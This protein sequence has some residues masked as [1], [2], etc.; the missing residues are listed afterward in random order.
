LAI[1]VF[2]KVTRVISHRLYYRMCSKCS[3]PA[4]TQAVDVNL[5]CQQQVQ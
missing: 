2:Q 1:I 5:T 3:S 4:R